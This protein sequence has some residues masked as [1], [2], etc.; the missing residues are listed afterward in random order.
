MEPGEV[1]A[2]KYRLDSLLARGGMGT[3]WCARHL[4]L[5]VDVALKL[6]MPDIA[7][8]AE[9]RARFER[10]AKSAA[11]LKSP[12][13]VQIHDY[14]VDGDV[15]YIVMELLEGEDL[16]VRLRRRKRFSPSEAAVILSQVGRGLRKA[17]DMGVVH[18]DLKPANIFLAKVDEDEVVKLLDFGIARASKVLVTSETTA[19]GEILGSPP[20]MSP[21]QVRGHKTI[22]H[23]TDQ[24][25]LGVVLYRIL[26][27]RLPFESEVPGDLVVRICVES[28]PAPSSLMP[29][30]PPGIDAFFERVFQRD[31]DK[32]FP[33]VRE[34]VDAF[35]EIA[36]P[37]M[38]RTRTADSTMG[39]RG[40]YQRSPP[41]TPVTAPPSMR[42]VQPSAPSEVPASLPRVEAATL[43]SGATSVPSRPPSRGSARLIAAGIASAVV[44]AIVA[45]IVL[46]RRPDVAGAMTGSPELSPP[47]PVTVV[48]TA[49]AP[50]PVQVERPAP[51]AGVTSV[52]VVSPAT[53]VP[54]AT[55]TASSTA[56]PAVNPSPAKPRPRPKADPMSEWR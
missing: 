53:A 21:E 17:H 26:T 18:R 51:S 48:P 13:V 5:D 31:L 45:T 47:S 1:V 34:M 30:P 25:S 20:Y 35:L 7:S 28:P 54:A 2:G 11:Q 49:P 9:Q 12:H 10:E 23:R 27:G 43:T 52:P 8:S 29:D 50:E 33:G 55:A 36:A 24:W 6:M 15:P 32:R 3:V 22:D 56:A 38:E 44:A 46:G 42:D 39:L 16:G 40:A 41:Q 4:A 14:G 37:G 19:T